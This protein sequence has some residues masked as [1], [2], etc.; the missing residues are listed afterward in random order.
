MLRQNDL[1]GKAHDYIDPPE[2][3][4]ELPPAVTAQEA[5]GDLPPIDALAQLRS[6]EL[7]RGARR[8]DVPV[9]YS[10]ERLLSAYGEL[11]RTW[12]GV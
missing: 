7:R 8:F 3:R 1:F 5:I 12:P 9:P 4:D 10:P 2:V 11:M 6:G